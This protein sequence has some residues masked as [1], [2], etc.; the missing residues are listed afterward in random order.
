V[1]CL[2]RS[3]SGTRHPSSRWC[4]CRA[5]APLM[6]VATAVIDVPPVLTPQLDA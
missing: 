6:A 2:G 4:G 5:E 3:R 1:T